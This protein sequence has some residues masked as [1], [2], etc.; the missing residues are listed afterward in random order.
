MDD[1]GIELFEKIMKTENPADQL[2]EFVHWLKSRDTFFLDFLILSLTKY[3]SNFVSNLDHSSEFAH[4]EKNLPTAFVNTFI[5]EL[6]KISDQDEN[7]RWL[8]F[9][10]LISELANVSQATIEELKKSFSP[11][12]LLLYIEISNVFIGSS[13]KKFLQWYLL[14]FLLE[15][16]SFTLFSRQV[17]FLNSFDFSTNLKNRIAKMERENAFCFLLGCWE[18]INRETQHD[19]YLE[20]SY[21]DKIHSLARDKSELLK[22]VDGELLTVVKP[23]SFSTS[24]RKIYFKNLSSDCF[25]SQL[26]SGHS[27]LAD[28][29]DWLIKS[30]S[31]TRRKDSKAAGIRK[32]YTISPRSK[33]SDI[34]QVLSEAIKDSSPEW[35]H[36]DKKPAAEWISALFAGI[37]SFTYDNVIKY[38]K[39]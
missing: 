36:G 9:C 38:F 30:K 31:V 16:D 39:N 25:N 29:F 22:I 4:S 24:A 6:Q 17:Y 11:E 33:A 27:S 34:I 14:P 8:L 18:F 10:K 15:S 32:D 35:K 21:Q 37:P 5:K 7:R 1:S 13:V 2:P 23:I 12:E 20:L 3:G 19:F 26:L 28:R